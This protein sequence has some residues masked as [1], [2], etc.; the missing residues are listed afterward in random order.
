[1]DETGLPADYSPTMKELPSDL[2]PRERLKRVGERNTSTAELLAI[3]LRTGVGGQNALSLANA[4]LARFKGLAGLARASFTEIEAVKGMGIA[5]S[6]QVKAALELGRR[7]LIEAPDDKLVVRSPADLAQVLMAEMSHLDQE[8][9]QAVFLDTRNQVLGSETIYQG[10]LNASYIRI[11]EV[12]R[13]AVRHN[14]AAI[15]VAHNH[16]SGDPT[17]SPEDVSV[18]RQ[19]V[20][21]GRLLDVEVLDH[22]VVGQQRFV[23]L[24]ERGLGFD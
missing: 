13:A 21:A 6:A 20:E 15:I 17:P 16:P 10:S 5:K 11:A 24:R 3:V 14:C 1:M 18:T 19:L 12:F 4:L 22:L 7:R 9:F 2:R 23:S 8:H